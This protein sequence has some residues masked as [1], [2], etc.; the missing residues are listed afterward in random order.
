MRIISLLASIII[1]GLTACNSNIH[2][3]G[4][5]SVTS[6]EDFDPAKSYAVVTVKGP[7]KSA[8][9]HLFCKLGPTGAF[10][11]TVKNFHRCTGPSVNIGDA[12]GQ[13][14]GIIQGAVGLPDG[15]EVVMLEMN[16]PVIGGAVKRDIVPGE[17]ILV[18]QLQPEGVVLTLL[19]GEAPVYKFEPG[20][21]HYLGHSLNGGILEWR[22]P[23]DLFAQLKTVFP[24]ISEDKFIS[25]QPTTWLTPECRETSCSVVAVPK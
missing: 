19:V 1:A 9:I 21:V 23:G 7:Q 5:V 8:G 14:I 24:Q 22:D 11:Y 10:E 25:V 4:E 3:I 15:Q 6:P 2:R 16:P 12:T 17:H 13:F 20:S 18:K